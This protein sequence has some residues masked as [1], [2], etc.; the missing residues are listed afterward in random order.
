[1][2]Q[3]ERTSHHLSAHLSSGADLGFGF[4]GSHR[5]ANRLRRHGLV[6]SSPDRLPTGRGRHTILGVCCIRSVVGEGQSAFGGGL[7][8]RG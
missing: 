3:L 5:S 4:T 7:V 6:A 8:T 1:M 2:A